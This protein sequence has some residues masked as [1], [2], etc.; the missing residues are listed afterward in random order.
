LPLITDSVDVY[1]FLKNAPALFA[2]GSHAQKRAAHFAGCVHFVTDYMPAPKTKTAA[3]IMLNTSALLWR[4]DPVFAQTAKILIDAF[5]K[6]F[7]EC[8]YTGLSIAAGGTAFA[9]VAL[10]Q[11]MGSLC[12]RRYAQ[13]QAD[14]IITLSVLAQ[15]EMAFLLKT[16]YPHA[17]AHFITQFSE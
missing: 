17:E 8:P 9:D 7:V 15:W 10:T 2:P 13:Y 1:L 3:K 6:N 5:G 14:K 4:E 11:E 12:V 16:C